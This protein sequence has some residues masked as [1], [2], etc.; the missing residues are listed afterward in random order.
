MRTSTAEG[1]G[2]G[3]RNPRRDQRR[4]LES[5]TVCGSACPAT[6]A[7]APAAGSSKKSVVVSGSVMMIPVYT[8]RRCQPCEPHEMVRILHARY[9]RAAGV[10]PRTVRNT[11]AYLRLSLPGCDQDFEVNRPMRATEDECC[12]SCGASAVKIFAPVSVAFKGTGFHNTDYRAKPGYLWT[13]PRPRPPVRPR[14]APPVAPAVR[15]V[16]VRVADRGQWSRRDA[17]RKAPQV[18]GP[19]CSRCCLRRGRTRGV[20]GCLRPCGAGIL[21]VALVH[22]DPELL[23][24]GVVDRLDEAHGLDFASIATELVRAPFPKYF[25]PRSISPS[26]TPVA[27]NAASSVLTRQSIV[28]TSSMLQRAHLYRTA[29]SS[30]LRHSKRPMKQPPMH[31]MAAHASTPSGAAPV[32]R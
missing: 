6:G 10:P 4:P 25:T 22:A 13:Q 14:A 2:S 20:R 3:N 32:P 27:M 1:D 16:S 17:T 5:G 9:A 24:A 31:F 29:F 11:D 23:V 12:P 30:S 7:S 28:S 21:G 26:V 19:S 15:R 18:R 8:M